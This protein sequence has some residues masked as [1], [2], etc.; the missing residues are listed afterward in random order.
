M[1]DLQDKARAHLWGHF[2][3]L[4]HY[5]SHELPIIVRGEGCRLHDANGHELLDGL[6]GLFVVQAGYGRRELAEAGA[7]QATTLNYFPL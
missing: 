3:R 2:T 4:A 1:S 6:S 7:Q 5:Q